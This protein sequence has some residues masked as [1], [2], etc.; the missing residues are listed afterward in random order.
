[1]VVGSGEG[2]PL[3]IHLDSAAPAEVKLIGLAVDNIH[4][5]GRQPQRIIADRGY[6]S[7]PLRRAMADRGIDLIA[8]NRRNHRKT[9]DGRKL[10]RY[11]RRWVI[12][13]T[14]AWL[15]NFRRLVVRYEHRFDIY[16]AFFHIACLIIT[17]NRF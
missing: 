9:A 3:G 11:R 16:R 12:E 8:P 10:R 1:M 5:P 15:G 17:L 7:D 4:V 14:M 6:D 13:R 2:V